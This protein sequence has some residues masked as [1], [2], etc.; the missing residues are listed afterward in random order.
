MQQQAQPARILV[1]FYSRTGTTRQVARET[2]ELLGEVADLEEIVDHVPRAGLAGYLRS[3]WEAVRKATPP[4]DPPSHAPDRYDLVLLATPVWAAHVSSPVRTWL[5]QNAQNIKR[6]AVLYTAH[7]RH[8]NHLLQDI[9]DDWGIDCREC[10]GLAHREVIR[11][12]HKQRLEE[13]AETLRS[14]VQQPQ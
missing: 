1:V 2:G 7:V 14:S 11:Q 13:F 5:D 8:Y 4:I 6:L 12:N 9:C 3:G 10:C